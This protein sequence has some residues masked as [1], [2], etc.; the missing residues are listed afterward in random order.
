MNKSTMLKRAAAGLAGVL[1]AAPA[2]AQGP[3]GP[4]G[5]AGATGAQAEARQLMG[6]YREVAGKLRQ[7]QQETIQA[8][9]ELAERHEAYQ[10]MLNET[11]VENGHS[12][13]DTRAELKQIRNKVSSGDVEPSERQEL[14]SEFRSKRQELQQARQSAMNNPEVREAGESL[15][16]AT[17]AAMKDHDPQTTQLISRMQDIRQQMQQLQTG[18]G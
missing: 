11:M 6:E 7:I 8:N 9:P 15:R 13:K 5:Q 17:I 4:G 16:T 1:L 2:L 10:A 14:R 3:A 12:P 18:A